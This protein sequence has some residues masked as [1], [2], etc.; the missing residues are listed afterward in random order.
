MTHSYHDFL[1][2]AREAATCAHT[3]I[4]DNCQG[5]QVEAKNHQNDLVTNIDKAAEVAIIDV[6]KQHYP[7]HAIMAEE[8]GASGDAD[9]CWV[10]DPIDGTTNFVHQYQQFS[11]SIAL[12]YRGETIVGL[13]RDHTRDEIFTAIKN[14]GAFLNETQIH[15][16]NHDKLQNALIGT[17][18]PCKRHDL[19]DW[20]FKTFRDIFVE[21]S[22]M[23]R[24]GSVAID[25]CQLACGRLDGFWEPDLK[26]WDIAAGILI[27][28]EAGGMA[29]NFEGGDDCLPTGNIIA[30]SSGIVEALLQ[31]ISQKSALHY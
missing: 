4:I 21:C 20:F 7:D 17:G 26:P 29:K 8:S 13:I 2:V 25:L 18:F 1:Q 16:S 28:Q 3:V 5:F 19:L 11:T 23:R 10:I 12:Q 6:I 15:I 14:E 30:G 31:K 27:V 24:G 22:D 9:F